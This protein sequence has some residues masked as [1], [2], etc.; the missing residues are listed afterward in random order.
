MGRQGAL[1]CRRPG[2][3]QGPGLGV[4]LAVRCQVADRVLAPTRWGL[5]RQLAAGAVRLRAAHPAAL[6]QA[7]HPMV[8]ALRLH[9]VAAHCGP[10][11]PAAA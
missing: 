2:P 10:T 11:A 6:L 8:R 7:P 9:W 5:G 3:L 4:Q 1:P